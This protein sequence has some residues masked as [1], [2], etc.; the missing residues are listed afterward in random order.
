[1][2]HHRSS[3]ERRVRVEMRCCSEEEKIACLVFLPSSPFMCLE[4]VQALQSHLVTEFVLLLNKNKSQGK[5]SLLVRAGILTA[6]SFH[7]VIN[8]TLQLYY[9]VTFIFGKK[10]IGVV[11][12]KVKSPAIYRQTLHSLNTTRI[13]TLQSITQYNKDLLLN[14]YINI[15]MIKAVQFI[16]I[17]FQ[18]QCCLLTIMKAK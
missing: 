5:T 6:L 15:I 2:S 4:A 17:H 8:N 7:P 1:M 12:G 13:L 11:M 18:F 3:D 10:N 14:K 16:V 9:S